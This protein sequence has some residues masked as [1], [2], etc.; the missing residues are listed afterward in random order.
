MPTFAVDACSSLAQGQEE[1]I[2]FVSTVVSRVRSILSP[3][4]SPHHDEK[5]QTWDST[6]PLGILR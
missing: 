5:T 3:Q 1:K 4:A 6:V 2:I